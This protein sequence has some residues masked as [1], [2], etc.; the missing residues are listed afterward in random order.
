MQSDTGHIYR[1]MKTYLENGVPV[2]FTGTPCQVA[3]VNR[4]F[5][6]KYDHLYTMDL[7]CHGVPSSEGFEKFIREK[8]KEYNSKAVRVSFRSLNNYWTSTGVVKIRS[9]KTDHLVI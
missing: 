5:G 1:E 9:F 7:I 4:I 2:L 6:Q 3:A 8:E